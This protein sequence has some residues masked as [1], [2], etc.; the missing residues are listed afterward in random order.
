MIKS[1]ENLLG[2][3]VTNVIMK[4]VSSLVT[5]GTSVNTGHNNLWNILQEYILEKFSE[6]VAHLLAIWCCA[7]KP[8]LAWKAA[9]NEI[10]EIKNILMP[11]SGISSY[12]AKYGFRCRD[13]KN[14]AEYNNLIV[15]SFPK[16]FEIR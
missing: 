11:L 5:D 4:E 12:L 8:S 10:P 13:L 9:N 7:N 3:N 15:Y 14:I 1:M 2:S 6:I 16:I